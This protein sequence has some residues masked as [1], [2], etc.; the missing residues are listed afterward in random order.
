MLKRE[1]SD[2]EIERIC[3]AE[4]QADR[5]LETLRLS[6]LRPEESAWA[7]LTAAVFQIERARAEFGEGSDAYR[8]AKINLGR[9]CPMIIRWLGGT[10]PDQVDPNAPRWWN[11][12]V[13]T[14]THF[15]AATQCGTETEFTQ[16][17]E[18]IQPYDS[19]STGTFVIHR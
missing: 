1:L 13:E 11:A 3:S 15:N 9:Y 19:S 6:R 14:M 17:S 18:L 7:V 2:D 16:T 5:S 8:A 12:V 10:L 4:K